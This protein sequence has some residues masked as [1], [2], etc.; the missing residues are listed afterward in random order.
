MKICI[1]GPVASG[2]ST[3]ALS[4]SEELNIPYFSMDRIVHND[5]TSNKRSEQEQRDMINQII[6]TNKEW[7]IEGMPRTHL[8]VLSSNATTII[9]LDYDKK[10]LR[11][12]LKKRNKDIRT[13]RIQVPY[14]LT[15]ELL[16]KMNNYVENDERIEKFYVMKKYPQKLLIIKNDKELKKLREAIREG[17][18]LKYQ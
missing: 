16:D 3:L 13:G 10:V 1:L 6:R 14:E 9:Y 8:E 5:Q 12:R 2:K 4:L 11:K 17:E 15:Q 18:V 7:I